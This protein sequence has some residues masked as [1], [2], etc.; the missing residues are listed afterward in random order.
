[1]NAANWIALVAAFGFGGVITAVVTHVLNR[2]TRK[3]DLAEKS[4]RIA[5]AMLTRMSAEA[6]QLRADL[7]DARKELAEYRKEP[8]EARYAELESSIGAARQSL[9]IWAPMTMLT[10]EEDD[11]VRA[12]ETYLDPIRPIKKSFRPAVREK[13]RRVEAAT[14]GS[15]TRPVALV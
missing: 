6:I 14:T 13:G 10:A 5:D 4:I 8:T 2:P 15:R 11:A 12:V 9:D 1:M 7:D 3:A